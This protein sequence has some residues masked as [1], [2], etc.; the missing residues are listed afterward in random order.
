MEQI[1]KYEYKSAYK[2]GGLEVHQPGQDV[3]GGALPKEFGSR[4][5]RQEGL[6]I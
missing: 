5:I 1:H 4:C 2:K 6:G 3:E